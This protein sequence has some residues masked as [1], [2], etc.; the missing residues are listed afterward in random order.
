[1]PD[2]LTRMLHD[3]EL[4]APNEVECTFGATLKWIAGNV[5]DRRGHLPRLLPLVRLTFCSRKDMKK[6]ESDPLVCASGTLSQ[7]PG[8]DVSWRTRLDL[9]ERCWLKP[10]VPKDVLFMFWGWTGSATKHL[11]TY[12]CRS[13]RWLLQ[14]HQKTHPRAYHGVAMLDNLISFV[15]GFDGQECYHTVVSLGVSWLKWTSRSNMFVARCYIS[16]AVFLGYIYVTCGFDCKGRT[17]SG[18]RYDTKRNQ[19]EFV[20][21]MHAVR[22]DACAAAA[23]G[24]FYIMGGLT[25]R[26]VL[27]SV[28][29]YDPSVNGGHT[30]KTA[31]RTDARKSHWSELPSLAFPR[32]K[33]MVVLLEG[34]I[35]VAGGFDGGTTVALVERNDMQTRRQWYN[36]PDLTVTCSAAAG[37]V[38]QDIS[39]ARH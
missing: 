24:L 22:S 6:V 34:V 23:D 3:D 8:S 19:R 14:N 39:N 33:L 27:D 18:E 28:E 13:S 35:Y 1:M 16:V 29:C 7:E 36:A 21:S 12:N 31:E 4:H 10:R 32:S 37:L 38:Y 15:G 20:A 9:S 30:L 17:S 2:E 11:L 25:G 26:E 5:E